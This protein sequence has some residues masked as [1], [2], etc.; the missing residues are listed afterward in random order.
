MTALAPGVL[1]LGTA[2]LGSAGVSD[3]SAED[4]VAAAWAAGV[5]H[6]DTAPSYGEAERRLGRALRTVPRDSIVVSTK[7]GRISMANPEP[8]ELGSTATGEARFDYSAAGVRQSV[9]DSLTRL[10]LDR[11][12]LVLLHDPEVDLDRATGEALPELEHLRDEGL[13]GR[14]G[15]GTTNVEVATRLVR[16]QAIGVLMLANRWTLLD[17]TGLPALDACAERGVQVLAAAP[18]NSGFLAAPNTTY[19]YRPPPADVSAEA[20]RLRGLCEAHGVSLVAAALQFPLRHPAVERVVAGMRSRAEVAANTAAVDSP[21]PEQF[22]D[23]V[24]G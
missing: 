17:R 20:A 11:V 22:W 16:E 1:G 5:R 19:D 13:A 9:E 21:I 3:A 18:F 6:F 7:V 12:D 10:G 24:A 14:I 4:V 23:A 15:V 8:Y 2:P